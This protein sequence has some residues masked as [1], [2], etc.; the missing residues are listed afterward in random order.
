MIIGVSAA[1]YEEAMEMCEAE[2]DYLGVGPVF[3]TA[4]KSDATPAIGSDE[5]ARICC[6]VS[7]P[8][9]AIGGINRNN[10]RDVIDAGADGAAVIAAV[11]EA[12]NMTVAATELMHI[13]ENRQLRNT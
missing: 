5:L 3:P 9:V 6:D 8:V 2:A 4:S 12:P 7:K 13:W 10:L 1:D 11:A